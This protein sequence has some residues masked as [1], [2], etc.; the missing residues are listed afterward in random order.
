MVYECFIV[1]EELLHIGKALGRSLAGEAGGLGDVAAGVVFVDRPVYERGNN[2]TDGAC[3]NDRGQDD[4][5]FF[6]FHD[7]MI[8]IVLLNF[9]LQM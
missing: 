8:L 9:L 3:E 5:T 2:E 7:S 4:D 1:R 6:T